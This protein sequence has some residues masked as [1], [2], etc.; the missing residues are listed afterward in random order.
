MLKTAEGLFMGALLVAWLGASK[1]LIV[2]GSCCGSDVGFNMVCSNQILGVMFAN[3]NKTVMAA[4]PE[5]GKAGAVDGPANGP[6][7]LTTRRK[8]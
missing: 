5:L 1:E 3:S 2:G 6:A 8:I 4:L 7:W